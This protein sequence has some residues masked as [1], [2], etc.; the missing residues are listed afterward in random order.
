VLARIGL[1]VTEHRSHLSAAAMGRY[2]AMAHELRQASG[3][4]VI[5]TH[6]L[7]P[8]PDADALVLSGSSAP[9]AAHDPADLGRLGEAVVACG[10]PVL[11][12]CAGMQ[13][14]AGFAGGAVR[15][16]A[17]PAGER[18]WMPVQVLTSHG[19]FAGLPERP[20]VRQDHGDEVVELPAEFDL[21]A[22]GDGCRV[23]AIASRERA[24]WGTQFHPEVH[25]A[26]HPD[27]AQVLRAFAALAARP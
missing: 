13:L 1:V 24:W 21:L 3:A 20:I 8:L 19:L 17:D 10:L 15:T 9:W 4:D 22:T 11:G 6:Y 16:M 26:T 18:G 2:A 27:G 7:E 14:L 25:D 12:I 23:Q 5:T